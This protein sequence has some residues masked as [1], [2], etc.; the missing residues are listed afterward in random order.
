MMKELIFCERNSIRKP[1]FIAHRGYTA[2]APE[3]SIP[4]FIEAGKRGMWAVETDVWSTVDGVLVCCHDRSLERMFN[5][6]NNVDEIPY[7]E[8]AQYSITSGNNV[9]G[10]N[11][12]LLRMPRFEEYLQICRDYGSV[13]F[14]EIKGCVVPQVIT[15]LREYGMEDYSVVSSSRFEHLR[16]TR[17]YSKR[18]FVHHIF[19]SECMIEAVAALGYSGMALDYRDMFSIPKDLPEKIHRA[20]VRFCFRAADDTQTAIQMIQKGVDYIPTNKIFS[21]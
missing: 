14:I 15:A 21:L 18:V 10:Y 3:N 7:D 20:D 12:Q 9:G 4:A 1:K 17:D 11:S 5:R 2:A 19:S 6:Q 16:E 8:L 13:P